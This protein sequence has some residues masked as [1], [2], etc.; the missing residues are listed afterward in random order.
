MRFAAGFLAAFVLWTAAVCAVNVQ[1]IGPQGSAVGLAG[2]NRF[3]HGVTGVHMPL[4]VLTDALSLIPAGV[5]VGFGILGLVQWIQRGSILKVDRSILALGGFYLAVMAVYLLFECVVVNSRPV[6]I[7]GRLEASYPSSTT[8]L[9]LCVMGTALIQLKARM[10]KSALR[11]RISCAA[12]AFMV[13]MVA[14]R[15]ISG[16][17]WA[18][19]VIGGVLLSAGLVAAYDGVICRIEE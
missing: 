8:V 19:D 3:V 1:A 11:R 4:Y 12:I 16:V 18:S 5:C 15:L 13:L 17:H 2:F 10:K 6:L 7:D 9:V 14:G